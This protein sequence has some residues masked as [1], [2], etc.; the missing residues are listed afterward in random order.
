MGTIAGDLCITQNKPSSHIQ[1]DFDWL[2]LIQNEYTP[3][4]NKVDTTYLFIL[5]FHD[6][7]KKN[8]STVCLSVVV[9]ITWI[10]NVGYLLA[11]Y[12]GT[13]DTR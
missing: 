3:N 13:V 6:S 1:Q 10:V 9:P 7:L 11:L 2:F 4:K 8:P 5:L 12:L